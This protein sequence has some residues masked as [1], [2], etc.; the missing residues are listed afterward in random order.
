[1]VDEAASGVGLDGLRAAY[2]AHAPTHLRLA[3]ALTA[4]AGLWDEGTVLQLDGLVVAA[5]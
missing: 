2:D 4:D 5:W 1:M 3:V